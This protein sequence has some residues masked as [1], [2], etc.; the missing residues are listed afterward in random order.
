MDA[1][2]AVKYS[3]PVPRYTSYP[4]APHFH[5]GVDPEVYGR[6]LDALPAGTPLSL[7]LHIPYCD[8]LCW[9]CGCNTK[10]VARYAPV[11][12]YLAALKREVD[13]VAARLGRGRPVRHIHWGGGS[14]TLLEPRDIRDLASHLRA[15]F[16]VADDAEFAVEIDPRD[17]GADRL[18]ALAEAGVN[19][20]SIGVQDSNPEVQAAI[21][22][23]QPAEVTAGA[24]AGLRRRGVSRI[25][26]D[27][28]YGLPFQNVARVSRTVD[29]V[30]ALAPDRL[31][32]F[33]YAHVPWMKT[34]QRMIPEDALPDAAGR[35]AQQEAMGRRLCAAGYV[36]VGLD[37]FARPED[38]M[39][40]AL[41]AGGLARNFQ[42]YTTDDAPALIGLGASAIGSLPQGYVQNATTIGTYMRSVGH[43][44]FATAKGFAPD[45][46]DRLRAAVISQLMC[47]MQVD[48]AA[49]AA[50][51]GTGPDAFADE[52]RSLDDLASD[53]L[54][55]REG[56]F[57]RVT[58]KGR[59]FLRVIC[60]AFDAYFGPNRRRDGG[61]GRHS[62]AV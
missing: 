14:P 45:R 17:V 28:M 9:F 47:A 15:A 26:V 39:A 37:H 44:R 31:A 11:K 40:A 60:A 22:R 24:V 32:V 6:W 55:E 19:R 42:G 25:N 13:M 18:D 23:R 58:E 5:A 43:G 49:A 30:L 33:G 53:G 7:Y 38:P 8:S 35:L 51:F 56:S 54:I 2:L 50:D 52:L 36:P 61:S 57:L 29:D 62:A 27:V 34:H 46:D 21:N 3:R 1:S 20:A 48:L 41:R 59:P 12:A 16:T 10:I 4:T